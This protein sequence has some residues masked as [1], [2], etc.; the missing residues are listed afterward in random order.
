L[1]KNPQLMADPAFIANLGAVGIDFV[2]PAAQPAIGTAGDVTKPANGAAI[3]STPAEPTSTRTPA[4]EA[5]VAGAEMAAMHSLAVA[6]KKLLTR[7]VRDEV[8]NEFAGRT[9]DLHTRVQVR[10]SDHAAA[11]LE[12]TWD[13]LPALG[14]RTGTDVRILRESLN[15]Y[16]AGQLVTGQPHNPDALTL[17]LSEGILAAGHRFCGPAGCRNRMHPL[18][19]TPVWAVTS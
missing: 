9:F 18:P 8:L 14:I 1:I 4:Q 6:G 19:C 16:C 11:L 7:G 3:E 13:L 5:L 15:A 17:F 12:G 10:D 2:A